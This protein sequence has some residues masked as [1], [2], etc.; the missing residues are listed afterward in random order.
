FIM[1]FKGLVLERTKAYLCNHYNF[2]IRFTMASSLQDE[3]D[4]PIIDISQFSFESEGL[5]NLQNH[6]GVATVRE[7]CKEWGFFRIVNTGV[8]N[9]I[10]QKL[11]SVSHELFAMPQEM[12]DR[13]ITSNPF[14]SYKRPPYKP[15]SFFFPTPSDSDSVHAFC[16]KL[17][18]EKDNLKLCYTI[19]AYMLCMEDLKRKICIIIL[20]SLGLDVETF[21]HS[22][23]EK[24]TSIFRIHYHSAEGKFG[25]EALLAHTDPHCFSILYQDN[26]GGLQI[27][28]KEGNWVDV[29]PIPNSLGINIADSLQAWS[30]GRYCSTKHRVVYKDWFNRISM[31]WGLLF[32]LDKEICAPVELVDERHPQRYRPFPYRAFLEASRKGITIES[33]AGISPPY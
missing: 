8:P 18:P 1:I 12:K 11:E 6:P 14:E 9:D 5:K 31:A 29:K 20:A 21:Y 30:N 19:V 17:W 23:F 10:F 27:E 16:N 15:E 13:A 2:K 22:D 26:G 3:V 28:S 32:P 24:G 33:Y 25:E 4:L 7:A